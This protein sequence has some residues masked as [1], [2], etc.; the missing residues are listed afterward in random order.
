MECISDIKKGEGELLKI[1]IYSL[2]LYYLDNYSM[3]KCNPA[4]FF[5]K[6]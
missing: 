1:V 4:I 3:N 6:T 2:A 5:Q